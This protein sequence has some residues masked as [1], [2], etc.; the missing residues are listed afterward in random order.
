MGE[1]R[2]ASEMRFSYRLCRMMAQLL[3]AVFFRGR[4][5]GTNRVPR[6]GGVLLVCNHQSFLDPV[7]ATLALPRECHYMARD[8]LFHHPLLRR[9]IEGLNAFPIRRGTADVKAIKETLRRLKAGHLVTTFPEATRTADGTVA[10]MQPGVILLARKARVPI[11]PCAI[12]GAFEAWP[13]QARWP[14]PHGVVVAYGEPLSLAALADLPEQE[15]V[16]LVRAR[17]VALMERFGGHPVLGRRGERRN[18]ADQ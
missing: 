11:V 3:Y 10:E 17:V 18:P 6:T 5:F 16:D 15:A 2:V 13:R 7:L 14:R 4:V 12:L 8:T 9:I 1:E